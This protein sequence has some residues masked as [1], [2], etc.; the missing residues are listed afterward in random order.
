MQA[1]VLA[2]G[3]VDSSLI[4][5]MLKDRGYDL[6]PLHINYGQRARDRE[7][8]SLDRVC[9]LLDLR[10]PHQFDLSGYAEI[11]SALTNPSLDLAT[12][13]FLPT[14]NLMFLVTGG[15]YAASRGISTLA[16]GL[17]A[18]PI[19]PDQT[20]E[21]VKAA[22]AAI[23]AAVGTSLVVLAPLIK[24]D[25]RAVLELARSVNV[26]LE[27]T[28]YCHSGQE[29]PCKKCIACQERMAA[30]KSIVEAREP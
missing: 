12:Q 28:Y 10:P 24:L 25:K 27:D 7:L 19:F 17:V 14:R 4:L 8:A 15:A 13:A 6:Y 1:V 2:S 18:N 20:E 30:E 26:P 9:N 5:K 22:E 16:I 3:G 21:F 23:K 29:Q 11:P